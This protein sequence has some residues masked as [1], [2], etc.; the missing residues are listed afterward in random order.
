[1]FTTVIC[2]GKTIS[3]AFPLILFFRDDLS[4]DEMNTISMKKKIK[5]SNSITQIVICF[6]RKLVGSSKHRFPPPKN[7][8]CFKHRGF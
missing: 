7:D 4:A 1:M 6:Q 5:K 8:D 2:G 3:T